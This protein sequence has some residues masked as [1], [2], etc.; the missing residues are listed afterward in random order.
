MRAYIWN[1]TNTN[2]IHHSYYNTATHDTLNKIPCLL[3]IEKYPTSISHQVTSFDQKNLKKLTTTS[4]L[5]V[6]ST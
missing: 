6:P 2:G 1:F 5:F 4:S 3:P